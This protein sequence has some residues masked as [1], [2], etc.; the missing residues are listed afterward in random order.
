M[1]WDVVDYRKQLVLKGKKRERKG[2]KAKE[3]D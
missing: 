2:W 1:L 3:E